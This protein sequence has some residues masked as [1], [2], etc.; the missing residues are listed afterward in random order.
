MRI[1]IQEAGGEKTAHSIWM[2]QHGMVYMGQ[3]RRWNGR[4]HDIEVYALALG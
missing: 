4:F 1:Y 3:V 2:I